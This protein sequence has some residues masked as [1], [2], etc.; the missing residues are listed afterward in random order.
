MRCTLAS[1]PCRAWTLLL[2]VVLGISPAWAD[3]VTRP[4]KTCGNATYVEEVAD[5]CA[6]IL[7][8][9]IDGDFDAFLDQINGNITA[10][11]IVST[12]LTSG[13]IAN[14]AITTNKILDGAVT[15]SKL[16]PGI[17][18]Y[19]NYVTANVTNVA[20]SNTVETT[21][22]TF[23]SV[24]TAGGIV[25]IDGNWSASWYVTGVDATS[26]VQAGCLM[27][28]TLRWK[29]DGVTQQTIKHQVGNVW[30]GT[31]PT[32]VTI[33]NYGIVPF[34]DFTET[35][36][37]GSYVYTLTAQLAFDTTFGT[38]NCHFDTQVSGGTGKAYLYEVFVV[39]TTTTST[40]TSTTSSTST[41]TTTSS[42]TSTT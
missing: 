24:T 1:M 7:A 19:H 39:T 14:N 20:I 34:P 28:V 8:A 26:P 42:T 29:R 2:A 10:A 32:A 13:A 31:G 36:A 9:E 23:T 6:T 18:S 30:Q 17:Q 33:D 4:A 22:L 27:T 5:G 40:S 25:V 35:P 37:A 21:T 12:G 11:N 16:N 41:S 38:T 3:L 15:A